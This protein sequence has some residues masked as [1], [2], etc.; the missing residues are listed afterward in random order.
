M[1]LD[2]NIMKTGVSRASVSFSYWVYKKL[3]GVPTIFVSVK[4]SF[5]QYLSW[6]LQK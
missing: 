1:L 2:K 3:L 4:M 6:V 5:F